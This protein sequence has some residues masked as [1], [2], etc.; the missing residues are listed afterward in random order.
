MVQV[1]QSNTDSFI[2]T[3][4]NS[5][6]YCYITQ[7]V[8]VFTDGLGYRG[9]IPGRVIPKTQKILL[10]ATLLNT[11]HY[12]VRIK[13]KIKQSRE[14]SRAFPLNFGVVAIEKWA[15]RSPS[16]TVANN[17]MVLNIANTN[18]SNQHKQFQVE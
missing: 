14:R 6:K 15:F 13:G 5:F 1:L 8:L 11:Q 9:S 12:K 7:M 17:N 3:K 4:L 16:T 10:N 2:C 18:N